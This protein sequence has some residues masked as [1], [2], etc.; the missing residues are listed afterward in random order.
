MRL[1]LR[2]HKDAERALRELAER[3]PKDYRI[4]RRRLEA[5]A[6]TGRGDVK[7]VVPGLFRLRAGDWRA[8]FGRRGDEVLFTDIVLRPRAYR[9]EAVE[10]ALRRLEAMYGAVE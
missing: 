2:F 7:Q 5:F 6:E 1:R 4:V 3:G 10:R 9:H 8:Y